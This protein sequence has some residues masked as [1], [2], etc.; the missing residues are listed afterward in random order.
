MSSSS[1][2]GY[3]SG[4][5]TSTPSM[6][7]SASTLSNAVNQGS[8]PK[9]I[10][11]LMEQG[12]MSADDQIKELLTD[13]KYS[14]NIYAIKYILEHKGYS[15]S[16]DMLDTAMESLCTQ[17]FDNVFSEETTI[18]L[19]WRLRIIT[20]I[21]EQMCQ[22]KCQFTRPFIDGIRQATS[23][24]RDTHS[25]IMQCRGETWKSNFAGSNESDKT[26][27]GFKCN[28]NSRYLLKLVKNTLDT[29]CSVENQYQTNVDRA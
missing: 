16:V 20:T 22:K 7:S 4:N 10:L 29:V 11:Q 21:L 14:R 19:E 23:K 25:K 26:I 18:K 17:G 1:T 5:L 27:K 3:V 28:H 24:Y 13:L 2:T 6:T 8:F 12:L 15:V 9:V